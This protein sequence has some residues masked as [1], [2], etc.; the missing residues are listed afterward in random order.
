MRPA[1]TSED[2][3]ASEAPPDGG[4]RSS[5][6]PPFELI[7]ATGPGAPCAARAA[8]RAW[9]GGSPGDELVTDALMV[10]GELVANSVRHAH[11]PA[12]SAIRVRAEMRANALLLE[13]A[14]AGT[15]GA[16][17]RRQPDFT[18]GGGFGLN[19]VATL[20]RRWGVARAEGTRVWA[21]LALAPAA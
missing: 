4:I 12:N 14:D 8:M 9:M 21:E 17:M 10:I 13:V 16:V 18:N 1:H 6:G 3:D 11:A 19:L 7:V 15:S 5:P 2:E 20:S